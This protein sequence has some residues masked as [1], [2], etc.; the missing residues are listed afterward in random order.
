MAYTPWCDDD[1]HVIDDG[2]V[3][4]LG[5]DFYRMTAADP[6]LYW[7]QDNAFGLR[8]T[9]EDVSEA[10][11]GLALQGP[12]SKALLQSLSDTSLE[13]LGYFRTTA[14]SLEGI[15]V[16][17]YRAGYTGD[18]GY[19]VWVESHLALPL[20][21]LLLE[22]GWAYGLRP[23]GNVA[24]DIARI[25]AGLLLI[26]ID[27]YSAKKAM[28]D[29]QKST[30]LELSL[31]WTIG[32]DKSGFVGQEALKRER[33]RGAAWRTVGLE[34]D[35]PSLEGVYAR[36]GMPLILPY[37]SWGEAVPVYETGG[38]RAQIGKATSGTWSPILKKYIAQ[39][40]LRP[41]FA[42]SGSLVALE[43]TVEATRL[44]VEARVVERPFY[45]PSRKRA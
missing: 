25:E 45:N 17:V 1:G 42:R 24:L 20:W 21:D 33:A 35:L 27:F 26:D 19:E 37:A 29:F 16:T 12:T 10:L 28:F 41:G 22:R 32:F 39:A 43:V 8:V 18:L 44:R 7:L 13:G 38:N 23:F 6:T 15:P 40:R 3:A 2:T 14:A 31:D 9:I 5:Q 11:A 30:P 34:V 36:F 4:H